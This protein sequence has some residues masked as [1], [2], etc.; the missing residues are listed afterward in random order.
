MHSSHAAARVPL[1]TGNS[2]TTP[3][4]QLLL[5]GAP[6]PQIANHRTL[7]STDRDYDP[8]APHFA[9]GQNRFVTTHLWTEPMSAYLRNFWIRVGLV[10]VVVGW[11]PL[12]VIGLLA[13]L[14][15]WPDP[16]PNPIGPGLLFFFTS[17][18]AVIC[19]VI[20]IIQV[21]QSQPPAPRTEPSP[22][23]RMPDV[24]AI[25]TR[26]FEHPVVRAAVGILGILLAIRGYRGLLDGEGRGAAAAIV[27]GFVA[28]YWA[29]TGRW[30]LRRRW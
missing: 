5:G 15:L 7:L 25:A 17:W 23:R 4:Q 18:P 3:S 8:G 11:G 6:E 12:L 19:F 9:S 28:V 2:R 27:L 24:R 14:G 21:R 16:N 26:W 30:L 22:V 29:F 1:V 20:G 10:L 13:T